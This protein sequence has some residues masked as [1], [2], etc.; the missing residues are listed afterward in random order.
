MA[1][2]HMKLSASEYFKNDK[3]A[4]AVE[5]R[6]PQVAFPLHDHDFNEIFVVLSGNGWHILNDVPHFITCGE[7]FYVQAEDRHEFADVSDLNLINILYRLD[8]YSLKSEALDWIVEA[9]SVPGTHNRHWQITEDVLGQVKPLTEKMHREVAHGDNLSRMMAESLFA[10]LCILLY[11][12]RFSTDTADLP[13]SARLGHVLTY[14]R[15]NC[16]AEID[17]DEVARRFGY[18][19][20]NFNRVFR[21]ATAT[22]P[23]NYLVKLRIGEAMRALRNTDASITAIAFAAGFNDS[24]YFSFTFSK[25]TGMTPSEY[26]RLSTVDWIAGRDPPPE[27]A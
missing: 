11:R 17:F 22:T 1:K 15:H 23:H 19:L 20:R 10:Q 26:R 24:N 5:P 25:L 12:N 7:V 21:E 18:S 27:A 3:Q 16:T 14:L 4:V 6:A 2:D 8:T 9:A 13:A